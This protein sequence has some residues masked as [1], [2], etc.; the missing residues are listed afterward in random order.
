MTGVLGFVM[1]VVISLVKPTR[2]IVHVAW[3]VLMIVYVVAA[4]AA[5]VNRDL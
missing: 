2:G 3:W 4:V 5:L 1:L